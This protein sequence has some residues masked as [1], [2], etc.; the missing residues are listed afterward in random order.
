MHC[1]YI[2]RR[3]HNHWTRRIRASFL[4]NQH[5]T[6]VWINTLQWEKN[7]IKIRWILRYTFY[8]MYANIRV[9]TLKL[10]WDAYHEIIY[11]HIIFSYLIS[12]K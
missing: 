5:A 2:Y 3:V 10:I 12:F 9:F 1:R 11:R 6:L 8:L 7:S 4:E